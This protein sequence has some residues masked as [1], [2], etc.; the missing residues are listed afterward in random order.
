MIYRPGEIMLSDINVQGQTV[1]ARVNKDELKHILANKNDLTVLLFPD[2]RMMDLLNPDWRGDYKL[3]DWAS[4]ADIHCFG[5]VRDFVINGKYLLVVD[6]H[7][8]HV[9]YLDEY[10]EVQVDHIGDFYS[11]Y[12]T[13]SYHTYMA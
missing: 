2:W 3:H 5:F 11:G 10:S 8:A 9:D 7:Q 6:A 13:L 12:V 1:H 4:R